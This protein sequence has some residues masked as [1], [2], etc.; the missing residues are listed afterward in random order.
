MSVT[1]F[2]AD[3]NYGLLQPFLK[4]KK[5]VLEF[6]PS[7]INKSTNGILITTVSNTPSKFSNYRKRTKEFNSCTS[8]LKHVLSRVGY[9]RGIK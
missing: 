4:L 2:T 9:Q 1:V 7:Y 5:I 6:Y 8:F 3:V